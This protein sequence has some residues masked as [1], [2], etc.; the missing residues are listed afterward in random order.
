[1]SSVRLRWDRSR[2]WRYGLTSLEGEDLPVPSTLRMQSYRRTH[3]VPARVVPPLLQRLASR[4]LPVGE[5]HPS[6]E[7][8]LPEGLAVHPLVPH[9]PALPEGLELP[10]EVV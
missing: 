1:M 4:G 3:L 7:A 10:E 2:G 8:P 6:R 9:V 5:K